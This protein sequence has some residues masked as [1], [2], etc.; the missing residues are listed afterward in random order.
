[1]MPRAGI[2]ARA[3][4]SGSR[5]HTSEAVASSTSRSN[6]FRPIK[7]G[8]T[9]SARSRPGTGYCIPCRFSR[10]I[11]GYPFPVPAGGQRPGPCRKDDDRSGLL[12]AGLPEHECRGKR[13]V[14]A[15]VYLLGRGKPPQVPSAGKRGKKCGLR[16]FQFAGDLLHPRRLCRALHDADR[17]GVPAKREPGKG[18]HHMQLVTHDSGLL[19]RFIKDPGREKSLRVQIHTLTSST[20]KLRVLPASGPL[21]GMAG[22][23]VFRNNFENGLPLMTG[24]RPVSKYS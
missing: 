9:P 19:C 24:T 3:F 1:M 8:V 15:E 21:R 11:K 16:M 10:K 4:V 18:I 14:A 20:E 17:G 2:A 22:H 5:S 6:R 23:E 12:A 13:R 7:T